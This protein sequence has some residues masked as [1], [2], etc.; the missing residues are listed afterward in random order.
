MRNG[1]CPHMS[2]CKQ[3]IQEHDFNSRCLGKTSWNQE[4]CFKTNATGIAEM[5]R[6]P[7]EWWAYKLIDRYRETKKDET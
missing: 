6:L 5:R 4:N 7:I 1:E 3:F 2:E